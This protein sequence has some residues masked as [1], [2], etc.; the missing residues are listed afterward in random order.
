M[1]AA[2]QI[3][4]KD[5][6]ADFFKLP[7][8]L[9]ERIQAK[10]DM[11]GLNLEKIAHQ[12]LTGVTAFKLRVGDYRVAYTFNLESNEIHLLAVGHRRD[13]YRKL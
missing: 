2:T 5:F 3:A 13:V 10:I 12:R 8:A 6:D 4:Y 11:V 9:Q 1:K 7:K